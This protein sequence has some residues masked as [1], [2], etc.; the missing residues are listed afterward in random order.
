MV[1][2]SGLIA[3]A[4]FSGREIRA[5]DGKVIEAA[6]VGFWGDDRMKRRKTAVL[7]ISGGA[8]SDDWAVPL[9]SEQQPLLIRPDVNLSYRNRNV[10][11]LPLSWFHPQDPRLEVVPAGDLQ[12]IFLDRKL[13]W[14]S[15]S[16]PGYSL[17]GEKA[18]VTVRFTGHIHRSRGVLCLEKVNGTWTFTEFRIRSYI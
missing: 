16:L 18:I 6:L 5:E 4:L 8:L 7:D 11:L 10:G 13:D 3:A 2:V 15:V 12:K 1:F 9:T 14:C 17:N